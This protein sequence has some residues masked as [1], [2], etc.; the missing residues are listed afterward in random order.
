MR[1]IIDTSGW[2][3]FISE[4]DKYHTQAKTLVSTFSHLIFPYP[5]FEELTA[6][7]HKR[8]GKTTTLRHLNRLLTAKSV[9]ITYIN[10]TDNQEIWGAYSSGPAWLDYVDSSVIW[11]SRKL[12]LPIFTFDRH[13]KKLDLPLIP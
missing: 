1:V 9:H 3:A 7:S 10:V 11:L 5:V 13:F 12:D 4:K 6:L 8:L 2:Y